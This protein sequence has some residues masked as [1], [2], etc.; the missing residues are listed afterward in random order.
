MAGRFH[1]ALVLCSQGLN[2]KPEDACV[3]ARLYHNRGVAYS[4]LGQRILAIGDCSMA[5][6]LSPMLWQPLY[7][8]YLAYNA[9]G[10]TTDALKVS[11]ITLA[12]V[13]ASC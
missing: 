9:I 1:D 10:A 4:N 12:F 11:L 6:R 13:R 7:H 3:R 5:H 2:M 8:R